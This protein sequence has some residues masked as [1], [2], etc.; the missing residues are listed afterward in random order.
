MGGS[1][2]PDR[3]DTPIPGITRSMTTTSGWRSATTV[4]AAFAGTGLADHLEVVEPGE[5]A[6][7]SFAQ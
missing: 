3:L 4:N 6:A 2:L 1:Q 5:T 7:D